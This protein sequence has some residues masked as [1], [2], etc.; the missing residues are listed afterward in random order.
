[1]VIKI[2]I[3]SLCSEF[4]NLFNDF[5]VLLDSRSTDSDFEHKK[6]W[7]DFTVSYIC[8]DQLTP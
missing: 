8:S 1:M 7:Y 2:K 3:Y 5:G 4:L 6:R